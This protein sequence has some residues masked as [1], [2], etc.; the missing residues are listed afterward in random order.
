ME[1]S[2]KGKRA[3]VGGSS[4]GL[5]KAI[6]IQ[7][8]QCGAEV[9]LMARNEERLKIALAELPAS[10]GQQ[11]NYLVVDYANF[12]EFQITIAAWFKNRQVDILVNNTNGPAPGGVLDKTID[13]YQR[14]FDLLF[15][16][17]CFLTMEALTG[18]RAAKYG[19]IINLSSITVKEPLQNLVLSNSIR[20]AVLSWSKTLARE[21]APLGITVNNILTGY[22][23]T[24]RLNEIYRVQSENKGIPLPEL[25]NKMIM[26]IPIGRLGVP[27]EFGYLVAF[28]A[29]GF[30][31][32]ITGANIPIDGGLLRSL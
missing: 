31:S 13:D 26:E 21:I 23:D 18:M 17:V 3:L 7:L 6:A 22:F 14:S 12:E 27:E 5:G 24:E 2:L 15:K 29:S 9:T 11:H 19:R 8:A 20:S 25:K 4:R 1:I 16:T 30:S 10:F 32:Y 28:L